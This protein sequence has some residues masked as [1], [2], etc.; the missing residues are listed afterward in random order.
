MKCPNCKIEILGQ[1]KR[2]PKC[3]YIFAT[4][5]FDQ[6]YLE[7]NK[8]QLELRAREELMNTCMVC[9]TKLSLRTGKIPLVDGS[10]CR[11][12]FSNLGLPVSEWEYVYPVTRNYTFEQIKEII[13]EFGE[14]RKENEET[15]ASFV[16]TYSPTTYAQFNDDTKKMILARKLKMSYQPVDYTAFD[17]SQIVDY[18]L[19]EDGS[20]IASGGVGRAA[21]G[22]LLFGAAGAVVGGVTRGYKSTCTSL[23]IKLTVKDYVAPAFFITLISKEII[24]SSLA[25]MTVLKQA[26]T[27]LSKLQLITEATTISESSSDQNGAIDVTEQIRKFKGLLDDGII[28]QEEFILKKKDL[29]NL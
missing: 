22:G 7:K 11:K 2:C 14:K 5:K 13:K 10:L 8:T 16:P 1:M 28:T 3:G 18:S 12:C 20:S 24:K 17:Y 29:L 9:G 23:Q 15:I 4:G 6:A 21:V 25:Y 26:E 19:L 27:I